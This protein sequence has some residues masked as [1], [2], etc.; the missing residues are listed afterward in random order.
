MSERSTHSVLLHMFTSPNPAT[1]AAP[2][3]HVAWAVFEHGT[4]FYTAPNDELDVDASLDDIGR[5]ALDA[6][7]E[8]GPAQPG[9]PS[10]DF[11]VTHLD[12][13]YP[14]DTVY[15]VT[16]DHPAIAN[17]VFADEVNEVAAGLA[18]RGARSADAE[19]PVIVQ[20]RDFRGEERAA[21]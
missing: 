20:V 21:L 1:G 9:S 8:L 5:A 3:E 11:N 2:P 7:R 15:F 13:W 10:G 12:A 17:V 19:H 16:Y 4:C 6:L 18:G 14:G